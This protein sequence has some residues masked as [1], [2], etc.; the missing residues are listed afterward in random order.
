L[1]IARVSAAG[2]GRLELDALPGRRLAALLGS[3]RNSRLTARLAVRIGEALG[4]AMARGARRITVDQIVWDPT[5]ARPELE[6]IAELARARGVTAL[7]AGVAHGDLQPSNV[8]VAESGSVGVIDWEFLS[9]RV[10]AAFDLLFLLTEVTRLMKP[11]PVID[12]EFQV[13]RTLLPAVGSF[14]AR[15]GVDARDLREY[16][17]LFTATKAARTATVDDISRPRSAA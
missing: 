17:P 13:A 14:A 16:L 10:P 11:A 1:I 4:T 8:I 3:A 5:L 9:D 6:R 15:A 7:T 2:R 12:A